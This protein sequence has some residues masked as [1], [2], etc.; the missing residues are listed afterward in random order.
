GKS[1]ELFGAYGRFVDSLGGRY[2][3]AEDVGT[4]ISDME[5]VA[6]ATRFVSGL[7]RDLGAAGGDPAPKTALGGFLGIKAAAR[8]KLGR[9]DLHDLSVAVQGVG[10]VGYHLCRLLAAEGAQ[11]AVSDVR[12]AA[13]E[14][15]RDEFGATVVPAETILAREVDVFA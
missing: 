6:R 1:A 2:V 15:A 12:I 8:F 9:T 7:G 3:T 10:G 5:F 14:R 4:T 11:L 13:A